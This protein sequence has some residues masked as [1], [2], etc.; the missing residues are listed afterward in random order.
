MTAW[1]ATF[2]PGCTFTGI[3]LLYAIRILKDNEA[4]LVETTAEPFQ[5]TV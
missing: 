5:R 2:D 4:E 3:D 1:T